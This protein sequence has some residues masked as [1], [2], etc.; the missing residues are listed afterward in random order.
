MK[1]D[2]KSQLETLS[3]LINDYIV[4]SNPDPK[5]IDALKDI[6]F[7]YGWAKNEIYWSCK[8]TIQERNF[9]FPM[10][11]YYCKKDLEKNIKNITKE[12]S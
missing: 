8:Y 11:I 3:F 2:Y 12:I 6:L 1:N 9:L 5:E 4:L 10:A 7:K